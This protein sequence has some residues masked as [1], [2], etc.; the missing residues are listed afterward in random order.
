ML[1][2]TRAIAP[3]YLQ[4]GI[5]DFQRFLEQDKP[6]QVPE[7]YKAICNPLS[8]LYRIALI[9]LCIGFSFLI[10][11]LCSHECHFGSKDKITTEV[12][13]GIYGRA[14]KTRTVIIKRSFLERYGTLTLGMIYFFAVPVIILAMGVFLKNKNLKILRD[15][16]LVQAKIISIKTRNRQPYYKVSLELTSQMDNMKMS[17]HIV[18]AAEVFCMF[19]E[20]MLSD[21]NCIELLICNNSKYTLCPLSFIFKSYSD[22]ERHSLSQD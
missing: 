9:I 3:A 18:I 6:R 22:D 20:I 15:G 12:T 14:P 21:D 4:E 5:G 19:K 17:R 2:H 16:E 7:K 10:I 8:P 1:E 13:P 11:I